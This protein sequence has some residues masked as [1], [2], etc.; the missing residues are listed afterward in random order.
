MALIDIEFFLGINQAERHCLMRRLP[1]IADCT[2]L[3]YRDLPLDDL[4]VRNWISLIVVEIKRAF[5]MTK[6]RFDCFLRS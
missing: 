4:Q 6:L 2:R 3:I 1:E 5:E